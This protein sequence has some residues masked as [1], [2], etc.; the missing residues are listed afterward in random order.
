MQ[1]RIRFGNHGADNRGL[2]D[3][4]MLSGYGHSNKIPSERTGH[5]IKKDR[6]YGNFV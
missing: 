6:V 4:F 1:S 3:V 5:R 2:A